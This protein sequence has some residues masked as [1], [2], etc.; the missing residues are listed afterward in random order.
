M[1]TQGVQSDDDTSLGA[2][3]ILV[4]LGL[5]FFV[6][7]GLLSGGLADDYKKMEHAGYTLHGW[8]GMGGAFFV[9]LR[10]M[11]GIC[12]PRTLRFSHWVPY[13][14]ERLLRAREDIVGLFRFRLPERPVHE[15]V[16]GLVESFG[17]V[18]L[19][20][21]AA[22]GL[23]LFFILEPG[24]K[25]TGAAHS[26]KE[27]HEGASWLVFLFLSM[28]AGATVAHALGGRHLWRKMLFLKERKEVMPIEMAMRAATKSVRR[29][30]RGTFMIAIV[31]AFIP[32][33]TCSS[34]LADDHEGGHAG[35]YESKLYGTI[36]RLPRDL[37]GAWI[38]NGR[39][40]AVSKETR[41]KTKHGRPETGAYVEIEGRNTGT[42]FTASE[43]KVK[44]AK[45]Y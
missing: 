12:G 27:L 14:R 18:A 19:L 5:V 45:R 4:H 1:K 23:L 15:G 31:A 22:S 33:L 24:Q 44:R 2:S 20:A 43:I 17:L 40:I 29:M 42:V 39:E 16:A 41:I 34:A 28:H 7:A 10:V 13:T 37:L 3:A 8:I 9:F 38:V 21:T 26:V 25:A 32:W 6:L 30:V 35:K 36:E 11:L